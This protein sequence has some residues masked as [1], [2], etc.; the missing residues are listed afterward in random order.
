ML[1]ADMAMRLR[2]THRSSQQLRHRHSL[3]GFPCAHD[4]AGRQSAIH[5]CVVVVDTRGW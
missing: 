3:N 5:E 2:E 1:A 4:H